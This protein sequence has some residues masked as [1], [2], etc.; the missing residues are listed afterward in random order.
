MS[1]FLPLGAMSILGLVCW[2]PLLVV[3]DVGMTDAAPLFFLEGLES[4]K[5]NGSE[6]LSVKFIPLGA[7][8]KDGLV[9]SVGCSE[10]RFIPLTGAVSSDGRLRPGARGIS[11]IPCILLVPFGMYCISLLSSSSLLLSLPR[12][13]NLSGSFVFP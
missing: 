9:F 11:E 8:S 7:V 1:T 4:I 3:D 10:L 6:S 12:S 13:S 2:I 5:Q